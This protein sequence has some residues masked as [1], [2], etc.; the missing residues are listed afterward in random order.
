[1][2]ERPHLTGEGEIPAH[3]RHLGRTVCGGEP[4][5]RDAGLA[6][7]SARTAHGLPGVVSCTL[8]RSCSH[9]SGDSGVAL[10]QFFVA[11]IQPRKR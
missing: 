11:Q 9:A 7:D 6:A 1:M 3:A 8:Q 2:A 4:V 5:L 10:K